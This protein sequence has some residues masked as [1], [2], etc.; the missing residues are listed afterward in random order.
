MLN[1]LSIR[2]ND[3]QIE[4]LKELEVD[5]CDAILYDKRFSCMEI[6]ELIN[7]NISPKIANLYP[8]KFDA[9]DIANL[10][11]SKVTPKQSDKYTLKYVRDVFKGARFYK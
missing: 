6:M 8:K 5:L 7:F 11:K 2:F 4:L 9:I 10:I 3:T 1:S